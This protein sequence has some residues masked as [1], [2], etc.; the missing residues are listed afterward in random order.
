MT[1]KKK[2]SNVSERDFAYQLWLPLFDKLF[3]IN[4]N[5]IRIKASGTR[6]AGATASKEELYPDASG[7]VGFKVDIR[8]LLDFKKEEFDIAAGE[9]CLHGAGDKKGKSDDSKLVREEKE[10]LKSM[11]RMFY[12][13]DVSCSVWTVQ[14]AGLKASF[15]TIHPTKHNYY[16]KVH[17]FDCFFLIS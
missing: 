6:L 15:S 3:F 10:M 5:I 9:A 12:D 8:V 7:V 1:K 16:V 14:T 4:S 11:E 2:H 17:Q 13:E